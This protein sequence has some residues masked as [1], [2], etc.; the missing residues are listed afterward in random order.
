MVSL[1]HNV[2]Q[3]YADGEGE[4]ELTALNRKTMLVRT[5][6]QRR[7]KTSALTCTSLCGGEREAAATLMAKIG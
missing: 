2:K 7:E 4:D 1:I 3:I 6:H 5:A